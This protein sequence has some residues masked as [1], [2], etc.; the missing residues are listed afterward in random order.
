MN[1][2]LHN[3]A[4]FFEFEQWPI[5]IA[6]MPGF[7]NFSMTDWIVGFEAALNRDEAFVAVLDIADFLKDPRENHEDKKL[8]TK[9]MKTRRADYARLCKGNVYVVADP[10]AREKVIEETSAQGRAFGFPF[11][12]AATEAEALVIARELLAR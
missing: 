1:E 7:E 5:V 10:V 8:A 4:R 12:G 2:T 3:P 11:V 9:W 6:R